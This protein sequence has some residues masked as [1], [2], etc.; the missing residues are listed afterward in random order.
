ML[1]PL[2]NIGINLLADIGVNL[3]TDLL[4]LGTD[5][6]LSIFRTDFLSSG[7][8]VLF[9]NSFTF[10]LFD[11][12]LEMFLLNTFGWNSLMLG[13]I[14]L[15]IEFDTLAQSLLV[16]TELDSLVFGTIMLGLILTTLLESLLGLAIL[17]LLVMRTFL[18]IGDNLALL[19]IFTL[20]WGIRIGGILV[21]DLLL[22]T[23]LDWN[24]LEF[25]ADLLG[26]MFDTL[27]NIFMFGTILLTCLLGTD[28]L[29][30]IG[31][32]D[33]PCLLLG[34]SSFLVSMF[35]TLLGWLA[36]LVTFGIFLVFDTFTSSYYCVEI[37]DFLLTNN[38]VFQTFLNVLVL[39]TLFW[40]LILVNWFNRWF[41]NRFV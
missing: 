35:D 5:L 13:T 14:L 30:S 40:L 12:L 24:L 29:A 1:L 34:A 9:T 38:F 25:L 26:G 21:T 32:T 23:F 11:A 17:D 27:G 15:L 41:D 37:T 3:L 16:F 28:L 39:E 20:D 33:F 19:Y 6:L 31:I 22:F 4:L 36:V 18:S 10:G 8:F 7:Q 2:S